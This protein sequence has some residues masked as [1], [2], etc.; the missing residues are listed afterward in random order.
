M[1]VAFSFSTEHRRTR[2]GAGLQS[3]VQGCCLTS[4]VAMPWTL[5]QQSSCAS[6]RI[7]G[8]ARCLGIMYVLNS[9][10]YFYF[11]HNKNNAH[12]ELAQ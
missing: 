6:E 4:L 7:K 9:T 2:V 5:D 11:Y 12:E 8:L 10:T 3:T 1:L